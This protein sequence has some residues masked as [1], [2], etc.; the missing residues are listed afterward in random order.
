MLP[1]ARSMRFTHYPGQEPFL[2]STSA[3]PPVQQSR[4]LVKTLKAL[5]LVVPPA[6]GVRFFQLRLSF[7]CPAPRAFGTGQRPGES[8]NRSPRITAGLVLEDR[9]G[10]EHDDLAVV[11]GL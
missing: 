1:G 10:Y 9:G 7:C 6:S 8:C 5:A 3:I 2:S 11:L 4:S